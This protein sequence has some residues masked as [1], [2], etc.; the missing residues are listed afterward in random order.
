MTE[1][2]CCLSACCVVLSCSTIKGKNLC[3][4]W[5]SSGHLAVRCKFKGLWE[6]SATFCSCFMF[7]WRQTSARGR[8]ALTTL[9]LDNDNCSSTALPHRRNLYSLSL[10]IFFYGYKSTK[11]TS[12]Y[13][14]DSNRCNKHWRAHKKPLIHF[15]CPP[16]WLLV[17]LPATENICVF[18]SLAPP[19]I[20]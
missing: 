9:H 5:E 20:W 16:E 12:G 19:D 11:S 8:L 18:P 7:A 15:D 3:L 2:K 1:N 17:S 10:R 6:L 4:C 13:Y 14:L